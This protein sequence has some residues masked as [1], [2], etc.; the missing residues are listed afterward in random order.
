MELRTLGKSGLQ[1][2]VIGLGCWQLGGDFGTNGVNN[3]QQILAAADQHGISFWDTADVYGAGASEKSIGDWQTTH[4]ATRTLVTKLGRDD[5][6]FPNKYRKDTMRASIE[7]SLARLQVSSLDLVQ[8]HCVP[9][10][11]L[12]GD[13]IWQILEGF[14]DEG[15]IKHYGASVETVEEGLMCLDKPGLTSLQIIFNL[16]RQDAI[17]ELLPKAQAAD[18]GI[19]ARLPLASGLLSGKF[20][21]NTQFSVQD[22]CHYNKDGQHFNVGETFSGLPFDKA[23]VLVN[24][25]KSIVP[26]N[27]PL[28]QFALRW[29]IDQPAV[30]TVIAGASSAQQVTQNAAAAALPSLSKTQHDEL[31]EFY[32]RRV[33]DHVRGSI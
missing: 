11:E 23:V 7:G 27:I 21:H 28:A 30:T 6:L 10:A 17:N 3:A 33:R 22:H 9:P 8:L 2:S 26:T 32:Q 1:A 14:R 25:L 31:S 13:T 15:L 16:F 4:S 18:V 24:E 5:S 19:I 29:L 20:A 12:Q